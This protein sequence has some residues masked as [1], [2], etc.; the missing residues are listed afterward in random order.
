MNLSP[1]QSGRG[2]DMSERSPARQAPKTVH[3]DDFGHKNAPHRSGE[4][5]RQSVV[6][7]A[8]AERAASETARAVR[9][10]V[11]NAANGGCSGGL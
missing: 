1:G 9:E 6:D 3:I 10:V 4:Q 5:T 2:F 7:R 11:G 8:Q